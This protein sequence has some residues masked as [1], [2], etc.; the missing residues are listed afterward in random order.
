VQ[1]FYDTVFAVTAGTTHV[2]FVVQAA[3]KTCELISFYTEYC[4]TTGYFDL[5]ARMT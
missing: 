2:G 5:K 1:K 3:D 4:A